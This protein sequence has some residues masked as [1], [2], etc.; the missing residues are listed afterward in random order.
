MFV[1]NVTHV[2]TLRLASGI[3]Q[4]DFEVLLGQKER[5][6]GETTSGVFIDGVHQLKSCY[7][8]LLHV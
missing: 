1:T 7:K 8:V 6:K 2:R 5:R 4:T 3:F